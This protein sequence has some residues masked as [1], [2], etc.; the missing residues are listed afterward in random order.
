MRRSGLR[1]SPV[2]GRPV[3]SRALLATACVL[4]FAPSRASA[5]KVRDESV[6][7]ITESDAKLH[8]TIGTGGAYTGYWFQIDPNPKFNFTQRDC[9]FSLPGEK[10]CDSIT[11]GEPLPAGL[12]EPKPEY[13]PAGGG[14]ESVSLDLAAIGATLQPG[15]L[16]YYRVLVSTGATGPDQSF[17]T[18]GG[19]E[20][21][22]GA[23]SP[24]IGPV[25]TAVA[26][27]SGPPPAIAPPPLPRAARLR[28][29]LAACGHE[30]RVRRARCRRAARR[31]YAARK[32]A[33]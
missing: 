17:V 20:Q 32:P 24:A 15:T 31:R 27:P 22:P 33:G 28:I 7:D 21:P 10:Q 9:P 12:V 16:Y 2:A 3:A 13:L 23:Q 11:D 5:A 14:D 29:A 4:M 19:P 1:I 25:P 6:T 8:A 26:V 30:P 18:G